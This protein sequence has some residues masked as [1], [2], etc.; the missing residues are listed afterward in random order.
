MWYLDSGCPISSTNFLGTVKFSNDQFAKIIGYDDYQSGNVTIS[1]VYY[2]EGL[3]HNLSS[4]GKFDYLDLEVA[5]RKHTCF[6][7]NLEGVDQLSGSRGTNLYTLSISNMMKSSPICLFSKASKTKYDEDLDISHETCVVRTPQHNCVIERRNWTLV[8]VART[9]LIFAN[10]LLFLWAKAV[11]TTC[12]THNRSLISLCHEETP[13]ELLHDKKPDLFYLHVFGALC[14]PTIDSKDLG[15]LKAKAD[16]GIFIGYAPAKKSYWIYNQLT[17]RIMETIHVDFNEIT[18]MASEQS[19]SRPALHEMTPRTLSLGLVPQPSSLTPLFRPT[20]NDWDTL[21]QPLFDEYF[22]P[23]PCLDHLVLEVVALEPAVLIGTPSSTTVD[24]DA[25][26]PSTLQNPQESPSQVITLS[27]EEAYHDIKVE[28]MDN[29]PYFGILIPKPSFE[30]SFSQV[31]L[32]E[33]GGMLK[34]KARLVARSYRQEEGIDFEESFALITRIKAICIFI[35]FFA[36]MNMVVYQMD[37]KTVFLNDIL[38]E[39]I[40]V[41]Q[42]NRFIDLE[43]PNHV[44]KLK[45]ALYGLKQAPRAWIEGKDISLDSCIALTA[46]ADTDHSGYQDIRRST[47]GSMQL[48]GDRLVSWSSKKQKSTAISSTEAEYIALSGCYAQIL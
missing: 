11:A 37:V 9:M 46:F 3:G 15:K 6:V 27:V 41:S 33:L 35:A 13:Y 25:P 43:N 21:L 14:Y 44:Y 10:A 31:K 40:Y 22:S 45:K 36:H 29:N 24:Q 2:V 48:L 12:Y 1:R 5:F 47:S 42:P 39:E 7:R 26:S 32:D 38:R 19:S 30:E 8:E 17:R 28:H 18:T 20:R 4:V 16:V 34:N 23:L